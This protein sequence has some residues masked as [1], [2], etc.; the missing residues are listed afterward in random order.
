MAKNTTA[1]EDT[2]IR[3]ISEVQDII[4]RLDEVIQERDGQIAELEAK[5]EAEIDRAND[6]QSQLDNYK[7]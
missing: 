3:A 1:Q 7:P 2:A 6:L 4:E 5:L